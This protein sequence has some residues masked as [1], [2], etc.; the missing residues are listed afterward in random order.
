MIFIRSLDWY[1]GSHAKPN[2]LFA[3]LRLPSC[4]PIYLCVGTATETMANLWLNWNY[5]FKWLSRMGVYLMQI[6]HIINVIIIIVNIYLFIFFSLPST[7]PWSGFTVSPLAFRRLRRKASTYLLENLKPLG[8][9]SWAIS[10]TGRPPYILSLYTMIFESSP[11]SS[12]ET[13][14]F[15][16]IFATREKV[17]RPF[18][19]ASCCLWN[20]FFWQLRFVVSGF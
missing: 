11:G 3:Y 12:T 14:T 7:S 8:Q 1:R 19:F 10:Y 9:I 16:S 5:R 18:V 13:K 4:Y 6:S 17:R 20:M 2:R 15:Q